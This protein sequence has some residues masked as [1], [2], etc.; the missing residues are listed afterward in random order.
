MTSIKAALFDFDGVVMDTESQYSK[1]W[2]AIGAKY[3][4]E[5]PNFDMVIKGQ[6]LVQIFDA[7][8]AGDAELQRQVTAELDAYEAQMVYEYLP[9][10]HRFISSLREAGIRTALVTSSNNQKM[11]NVYAAHPTFAQLFDTIVTANKFTHS[12]PHPECF[13]LAASELGAEPANCVVFEDSL[14]GMKAGRSAG[15][16][17]VGVATTYSR[18]AIGTHADT[19]ID[20]FEPVS[21]A[22]FF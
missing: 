14:H 4:P 21:V 2:G 19:I 16:K 8:F 12:K 6:T 1:I 11:S 18:G 10:V 15:M 20:S 9:G 5:I 13:L 7:H 3:H 22:D 17:V